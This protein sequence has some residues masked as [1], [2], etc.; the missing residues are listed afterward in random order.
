MSE[1]IVPAFVRGELVEGPLVEFGGRGGDASFLAPDPLSFVDRLA[2]RS[3]SIT[4][5]RS[6]SRLAP[7]LAG[8]TRETASAR[9]PT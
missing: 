7:G 5:E 6:G 1:I 4:W 8:Q 9:S 3:P 2:L